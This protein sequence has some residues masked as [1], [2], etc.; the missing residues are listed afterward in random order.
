MK[1]RVNLIYF[2]VDYLH[3]EMF[4]ICKYFN[5]SFI[6][7]TSCLHSSVLHMHMCVPICRAV[8]RSFCIRSA[9]SALFV[10]W[11][12]QMLSS[13]SLSVGVL[14]AGLIFRYSSTASLPTASH[15]QAEHCHDCGCVSLG[16]KQRLGASQADSKRVAYLV[17]GNCARP[18]Q[19]SGL[20]PHRFGNTPVSPGE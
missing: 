7:K 17:V 13:S 5:Y 19:G 3:L 10:I 11:P 20:F 14:S 12:A 16:T 1:Y 18:L 4:S 15:D 9:P 8:R 6:Y 2:C